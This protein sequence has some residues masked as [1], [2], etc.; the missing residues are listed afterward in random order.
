MLETGLRCGEAY[1]LKH[2]DIFLNE[3]YLEVTKGK[4]KSSVR[5]VHL[6]DKARQ[7]LTASLAGFDG[8]NLFPH[9]DIDGRES[10]G[11]LVPFHLKTIRALG[12]DFRIYDARHSFATK[13]IEDGVDLLTL[14][15]ILGHTNLKMLNLYAHPSGNLKAEAIRKMEAKAVRKAT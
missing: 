8:E 1:A 6:S 12:F 9:N 7:I 3:V 13:A 15:S 4:N 10:T 5:R 11:S 2:S 14:A